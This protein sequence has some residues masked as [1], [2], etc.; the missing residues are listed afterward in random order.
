MRSKSRKLDTLL[1]HAG[2]K[3]EENFGI[4]NPPVYHASTVLF[5]TVAALERAQRE[6]YTMVTYGRHGTPTSMAL[7]EAVAA[8]EGGHRAVA[9]CS[10][11]AACFAAILAFVKAGDHVL[12]TDSVYG[13]VRGFCTGFLERF[14]VAATFYDPRIG[15][16]IDRLVRPETRLV[17]MESPGSLTFEVQ[18]VPAIVAVAKARGIRAIIDNTWAAPLFF[19]P[20]ALGVDVEVISATKYIVGHS[21]AMMGVAVCTEESFLP[22]RTAATQLGNHA[23]P[24]D[25][26]L[27]L[28]GLRSAGVRLRQH[29]AQGLAL[30]NWLADRPE[31]RQVLH[32][33]L[34]KSQDHALWRRDFSG[35]SGLFAIVLRPGFAKQSLAA[36]LDG[37][38]LFGMGA[39]W[40]GFESLILPVAP[41]R[42][43]TAVPWREGTV[44]RLHAGLEDL[45]DLIA[46]LE[47]GFKRLGA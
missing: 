31:V 17:Y 27:A 25:C 44:L 9:F 4:V 26:Y 37:M 24:D 19:K 33:G 45:G 15:A 20:M 43:R 38:E 18:D 30:A 22:V 46:D 40:G 11:A 39:S 5:P 12:V 47:A 29:Q 42:L 14:G 7:E 34:A 21:D 6:R 16:G 23:A 8:V 36:M 1:A 3:P 2:R 32:P 28:R 10:G 13:P 35:A 41:E